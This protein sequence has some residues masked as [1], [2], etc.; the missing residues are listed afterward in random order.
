LIKK[1]VVMLAEIFI[2]RSEAEARLMEDVLPSSTSRFIAF[3]L[4]SQADLKGEEAKS[5]RSK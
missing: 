1:V 2:V 4:T 3:R 5:A